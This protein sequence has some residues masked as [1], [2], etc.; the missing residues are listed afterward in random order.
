MSKFTESFDNVE[1][2]EEL[3][4]RVLKR[5]STEKAS[6]SSKTV[7]PQHPVF[8]NE[9]Q[10]SDM[11]KRKRR[12]SFVPLIIAASFLALMFIVPT[13]ATLIGNA[14]ANPQYD[15]SKAR[16]VK[17]SAQL[18][19]LLA[20][21]EYRPGGSFFPDFLNGCGSVVSAPNDGDAESAPPPASPGA[22]PDESVATPDS[23][24]D[25]KGN[26]SSTNV[27]VDGM[28]EGD[29]IK[30]DA[31]YIYRLSGNGF[32]IAETDNGNLTAVCSVP[33]K[34]FSPIEMYI[35][36]NQLIVVGG[37]YYNEPYYGMN[38]LANGGYTKYY[39]YHQ[40]VE[41]RI[42]DLADLTKP[43]LE[44]FFEVDGNY[45]T[46][47]IHEESGTL[48]F[49]VNYYHYAYD[50]SHKDKEDNSARPFARDDEDA[51]PE[52]MPFDDIYYFKNNPA[53]A[54]MILGKIDLNNPE[55]TADT[56]AYLS[57]Q[58]ILYL[59]GE[60]LYTSTVQWFYSFDGNRSES[61]S[62]IAKFSLS[63]LG[64]VGAGTVKGVPKDRYSLDEYEGTLRVASTYGFGSD[65]AAAVYVFDSGMKELS[66]IL[67]IAKG[68]GIDS[69]AFA[70]VKGYIT[71]SPRPNFTD[72]LFILDF[73]DPKKPTLSEGL[74]EQGIN[75]Y[76]KTIKDSS[77]VLGFGVDSDEFGNNRTG[78][79]V[80]L[81]DMSG[82]APVSVAKVS[83]NG[84]N[85]Y[86]EVL[87][88]PKALLY[89]YN[90]VTQ[91]GYFGFSAERAGYE[92]IS[93]YYPG[94]QW[95]SG[96]WTTYYA[97]TV[98]E[99]GFYL[100]TFDAANG[101]M[102]QVGVLSN[103]SAGVNVYQSNRDVNWDWQY[104]QQRFG[105][106]VQRGIIINDYIYTV[107]NDTIT[108]YDLSG[109]TETDRITEKTPVIP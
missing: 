82:S 1:A 100:F 66:N 43:V 33:L 38:D 29:I 32:T 5:I 77:Y 85:S 36:G 81:Y 80:Q 34:N 67:E 55:S 18:K 28:D 37:V 2:D 51:I 93:Y 79:K 17:D 61:R 42:Y 84:Q 44:R 87:T 95:S 4:E 78:L 103:F 57:N 62:Y 22:S 98:Y 40:K 35:R 69:A 101:T 16:Q 96:G 88:N 27:Q 106:Y 13:V 75:Q 39:S 50:Y 71:T 73:T 108:A 102:E 47:R 30:N 68:E 63:D 24:E 41:I 105:Q 99:Q 89:M 26:S 90:E 97:Y 72:P 10:K 104:E 52:P 25:S 19:E 83:I 3:K 65:S 46:S 91:T 60:N 49:V 74:K 12:F 53:H 94:N 54:Y 14:A 7:S 11:P 23:S 59:S 9:K 8:S 31:R 20:V 86:A 56:K 6:A 15:F 58:N 76:L 45:H 21:Q 92:Q 107:A 109:L 70:G 48:Y 64:Y